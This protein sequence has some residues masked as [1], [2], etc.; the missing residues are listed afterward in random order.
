VVEKYGAKLFSMNPFWLPGPDG[1]W[2]EGGE[3]YYLAHLASDRKPLLSLNWEHM[4]AGYEMLTRLGMPEDAWF[5]CLHARSEKYLGPDYD[6][7][8]RHRNTD[9]G[10]F[11]GA[12]R[13]IAERGGWVVRIS[14]A[15][16]PEPLPDWPNTIDLP[17]RVGRRAWMDIWTIAM[18]RFFLGDS[19]GPVVVAS[20][21]AK[22]CIAANLELG[23]P[24]ATMDLH[25]P[26][27]FREKRSGR[28]IKLAEAAR[29]PLLF[30]RNAEILDRMGVEIVDNTADEIEAATVEMLDHL[31]CRPPVAAGPIEIKI[32]GTFPHSALQDRYR[33]C[34]PADLS[35]PLREASPYFLQK[36]EALLS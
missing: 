6:A 29:S 28:M 18:C 34:F 24:T 13:R 22:P 14:A 2:H 17:Y 25:M 35:P 21:F 23:S 3:A 11:E 20:T 32:P 4:D 10:S 16:N 30:C 19:S 7:H 27:L 12:A 9:I 31:D 1:R 33:R 8:N 36:H 15:E 26:K 5:V